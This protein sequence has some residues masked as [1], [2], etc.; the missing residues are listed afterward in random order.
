MGTGHFPHP[1]PTPI[2]PHPHP[3]MRHRGVGEGTPH[4]ILSRYP[5]PPPEN[6]RFSLHVRSARAGSRVVGW[7]GMRA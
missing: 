5:H 4:P 1:P 6:H 3:T 7:R 2:P